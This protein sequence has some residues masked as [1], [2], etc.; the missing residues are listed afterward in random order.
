MRRR[1]GSAVRALES[2]ER[3]S[4]FTSH[5]SI[6]SR[7]IRPGRSGINACVKHVVRCCPVRRDSARLQ[8][9][10]RTLIGWGK[11][12]RDRLSISLF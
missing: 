5:G 8:P 1:R 3:R 10:R 12:W 7:V 11:R 9:I 2:L 4:V 6:G